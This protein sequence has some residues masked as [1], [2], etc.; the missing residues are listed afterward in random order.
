MELVQSICTKCGH[1]IRKEVVNVYTPV[2]RSSL[3]NMEYFRITCSECG[4]IM[5]FYYP[6]V[7]I[8]E[9]KQFVVFF[10]GGRFFEEPALEA[11]RLIKMKTE[12]MVARLCTTLEEF[13]E[14]VEILES[15]LD[16][17]SM[18]LFKLS[19]FARIHLQDL[20]L[21]YVYFYRSTHSDQLEFTLISDSG[22]SGV[23]ISG[24][25]F[26]EIEE[27]MEKEAANEIE[28]GFLVIDREWAGQKIRS[29]TG[30]R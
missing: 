30:E 13:I 12:N 19:L 3:Q 17:R 29:E 11:E 4:H 22:N 26:H 15:G 1:Q 20:G 9:E 28:E 18:E 24:D 2:L 14:K 23:A 8:N 21:Q 6:C 25:L 16:D 10:T 5:K 7:Y 27:I